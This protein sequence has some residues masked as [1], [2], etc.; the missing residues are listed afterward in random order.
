MSA[1][2]SKTTRRA[3]TAPTKIDVTAILTKPVRVG[4][5]G[6]DERMTPFEVSLRALVKKALKERSLNAIK[7]LLEVAQKHELL[8]P[9]PPPALNG[10]VRIWPGIRNLTFNDDI[11]EK[12]AEACGVSTKGKSKGGNNVG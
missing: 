4:K 10:G 7:S 8:E 11:D 1:R 5:Q 9:P 12:W 3:R 6:R 2:K